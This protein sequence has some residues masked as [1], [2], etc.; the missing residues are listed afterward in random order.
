LEPFAPLVVGVAA[1]KGGTGKTTVAF[2][3]GMEF[4]RPRGYGGVPACPTIFIDFDPQGNRESSGLTLKQLLAGRG[5]FRPERVGEIEGFEVY[6]LEF[7]PDGLEELLD[8]RAAGL[9]AAF[10]AVPASGDYRRVASRKRVR[11]LVAGVH[12]LVRGEDG[13]ARPPIAFVDTPPMNSEQRWVKRVL[14]ACDTIVPVMDPSSPEQ[15]TR[16]LESEHGPDVR[17]LVLNKDYK[18][19]TVEWE[20]NLERVRR[21]LSKVVGAVDRVHIPDAQVIKSAT[22]LGIPLRMRR[23]RPREYER[24]FREVA[25]LIAQ[26]WQRRDHVTGVLEG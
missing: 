21:E 10:L 20:A 1:Y 7:E 6:R 25:F 11:R 19:G 2:N 12:D 17:V 23:S 13:G 5:P 26:Y 9:G 14:R 24:L 3:V 18:P 8:D 22:D 4:A 15:I 16:F